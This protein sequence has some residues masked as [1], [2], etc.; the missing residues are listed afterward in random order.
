MKP[1]IL[2]LARPTL[3]NRYS[4]GAIIAVA[5]FITAINFN[6]SLWN[7]PMRVIQWDIKS[8][9]AYLPATII[10][11]DLSLEFTKEDPEFFGDKFWP[12]PTPVG[13]LC[14]VM[15]MGLSFLYLPFF[16][17]GH[18][19][20]W[21]TGAE[22]TG[23]STPYAF[24][25]IFSA[26][27]YLVLAM[28]ILR[29]LLLRYFHDKA[30]ALT[31]VAVVLGTNLLY[32]STYEA[33]MSHVFSFFLFALFGL[34]TLQWHKTPG[35]KTTILLGLTAGLIVL[36][37][38][39]NIVVLLLFVLW[40]IWSVHCL[41][42][43]I[44]SFI[45]KWPHLLVMALM[46]ILVWMPQLFYWKSVS[47]QWLYYSYN[48]ESFFFLQPQ[49]LSGLFSYRKGWFVYTPM[50]LVAMAG[51]VVVW[52]HH[53]EFFTPIVAYKLI[54]I[55]VVLSWW[56]WWYGGSFGQRPF[57]E[58]YALLSIPLAALIHSSFSWR[59]VG[60][61]LFTGL[62]LLLVL[63]NLFQTAQ[64]R[65]GA[66][67]WDAMG[68]SA[69]WASFGRLRPLAGFDDILE[70]PDYEKAMQGV[71][72]NKVPEKGSL[73]VQS[74]RSIICDA[75]LIS[76]DRSALVSRCGD[77]LFTG[78]PMRVPSVVCDGE[79]AVRLSR[80]HSYG[81]QTTIDVEPGQVWRATV[82][83]RSLWHTGYLF[84]TAE[85]GSALYA[86]KRLGP[87]SVCPGWDSLSVTVTIPPE[88]VNA[89]RVF[90]HNPS[91]LPAY[92]DMLQIEQLLPIDDQH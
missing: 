70:F 20:A 33:P 41:K 51:L 9:Y 71:Y 91:R 53:R 68:K 87:P 58:S 46:A 78:L 66:I 76:N 72:V 92:F 81:L 1:P 34:L 7:N 65:N 27:F 55:Y 14:I 16:L 44:R 11:H 18:L 39:T 79:H 85:E 17:L 45:D 73:P 22:M 40:D 15:S 36:I 13:G 59:R 69:Y 63:H 29:K 64:Y 60:K 84:V 2:R 82:R 42:R 67:H 83:R 80:R 21:L 8:Y 47:G 28:L 37:R 89:I 54:N 74:V 12:W 19:L 49:I 32:Y 5:L 77:Y 48:E 43:R 61:T 3:T 31:L 90:A 86:G 56:T 35:W 23:Y 52:K 50:M 4:A 10:Y 25:L 62:I 26:L 38:P 75:E 30:V 88:G 57:I 24:M 6:A